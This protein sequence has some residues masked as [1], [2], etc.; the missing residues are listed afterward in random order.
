MPKS[1]YQCIVDRIRQDIQNGK[2]LKGQKIPSIRK[3]ADKYHCSKD[4]AQKAL[5]ELKYQ[6]YIYAVPK[7]G[8]YVLENSLEDQQDMELS[9][10]DDRH[11]IY[12][13]FRICLNETLIGRE[14]YLFNYYSQQEGLEDLRQSV[15]Q[16]LLDSVVY[17][18]ADKLV[19]TSGTQQALYILSQ[20]V[21][22]NEKH[23]I[24]VEQ[25]TYHRINDLLTAQKLPYQ[26]IERTP[27]GIDLEE[28]EWIFR[29]GH[30][31]FFY[32][33]PRF[34]YP[35]EHS[36]NRKEKEE[37]IRLAQLYDVYIVEDDYL[38]DF[39]SK[40]ELTFHYLDDSQHVIY[41]KSFSASL[42]PALRITALL[43]PSDIQSAFIAYK[44]AVDYDSNLIMQ[45]A[46][47]LYIDNLMFEKNRLFL[48]NKQEKEVMR[49]KK[50]L[51]ENQLKLSYFL[52]RDGILLDL[53]GLKSVS[54]F[55]HSNLP[56]DFFE[57][58]YIHD[59]PYQYAKIRYEN[60]E[61]TLQHLN[62]YL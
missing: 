37:I 3:L 33:I 56:L 14:N 34:H 31:K 15:Q 2:L 52:N 60:L 42:F 17:T 61:K 6:K 1:K 7:S 22:P 20:I 54:S 57:S 35:L 58:S 46:L 53:R 50:L 48:L 24:L 10:R 49:A 25:P 4:T 8:Y 47:S 23:E 11:Q 39:D 16:L 36:Y 21:F 44:K 19:L 32:T 28:L 9:V 18:S 55:K 12:E 43:L 62:K 41:I 26:T 29:T 5:M 40:H 51:S 30:I 13:D 38:A 45:K 59:C 27:E